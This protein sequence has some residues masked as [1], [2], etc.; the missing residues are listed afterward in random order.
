MTCRLGE[1]L[2]TSDC[3]VSDGNKF[4]A[5]LMNKHDGL[6]ADDSFGCDVLLRRALT[7]DDVDPPPAFCDPVTLSLAPLT[8]P[9]TPAFSLSP[10]LDE[11][12]SRRGDRRQ[13]RSSGQAIAHFE[14]EINF[15]EPFR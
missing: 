7:D 13:H 3:L 8:P 1:S 15:C 9:F 12:S 11:S 5:S 6:H 14:L 10:S 2:L 4:C